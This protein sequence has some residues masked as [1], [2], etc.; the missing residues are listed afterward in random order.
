M[1][2]FM[3]TARYTAR[4]VRAHI[5]EGRSW[6]RYEVVHGELL[7]TPAPAPIHQLLAARLFELLLPYLRSY[8]P[9]LTLWFSPADIS[10]N[11]ETLVQPDLFVVPKAEVSAT[12]NTFKK[13]TLAV[14]IISPSS[15]RADRVVKRRLY[16]EQ[17]VPTYWVVDPD[18]RIVEVWHP[19]ADRPQVVTDEL[20]WRA[21]QKPPEL[22]IDLGILF[23]N[24]PH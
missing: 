23:A 21:H 16:Q 18:S 17:L 19:E 4:M 3:P 7:V 24:L 13:L 12:W 9:D 14:E 6:P 1:A 2:M 8:A 22:L 20:R 10:W 11:D 15:A 5:Q